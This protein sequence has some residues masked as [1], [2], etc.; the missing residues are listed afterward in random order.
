MANEYINKVVYGGDT[1]I[2]LT[3]D[4]ITAADVINAKTFHDKSGAPVTGT[5]TYDADTS[6]ATATAAEI[7]ATKTAYA[8]GAKVTGT[9]ANRGAV[10]GTITS[11]AQ[12]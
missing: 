4:T 7:L 8:N 3:G 10:T 6:D 12:Q 9:M 5:C 1:L 11:K 2:D